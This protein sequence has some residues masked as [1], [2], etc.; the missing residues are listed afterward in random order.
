MRGDH[1]DVGR[2]LLGKGLQYQ[3]IG[4]IPHIEG[5]VVAGGEIDE[6]DKAGRISEFYA[7]DGAPDIE[8]MLAA[9]HDLAAAQ[10]EEI[11]AARDA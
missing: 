2:H 9:V 10:I 8:I 4:F 1:C 7:C 6:A 3:V 11:I 5:L